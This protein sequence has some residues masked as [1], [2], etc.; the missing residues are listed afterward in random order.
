MNWTIL[1]IYALVQGITELFPVSSVGHAVILPYLAGWTNISGNAQF[2]PF[3]VML[4][5]GTAFALIIYF[6]RDW[7]D[8]I[9]ALFTPGS[10]ERKLLGRLIAATIPAAVIGGLLEHK[11]RELFPSALSAGIFL[12]VNGFVLYLADRMQRSR[13]DKRIGQISYGQS[14]FVGLVQSL[15][16]IP[17]F[18]RS[19]VTMTAGLGVGLSYEESARFSFLLA[20]PV[21]LGAGILE[22][23]KMLKSHSTQ[24]IHYGV[25][26]GLLAGVV[27]FLS[28]AFLMRYFQDH[29]V[30]ALR[31]FALY[32]VIAGAIV[33]VLAALNIHL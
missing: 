4:H 12:I 16:L 11:F 13:G 20:T 30:R 32:C 15:A 6:W 9:I 10:K 29:E 25:V 26:G 24:M 1:I 33:A 17:G 2:L 27:A 31:P 22:V 19:G 3:V 18:S 14:F 5:L 23:P 21:I 8:L 28:T 7:L